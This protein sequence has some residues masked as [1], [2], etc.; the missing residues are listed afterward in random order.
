MNLEIVRN[1]GQIIPRLEWGYFLR[2]FYGHIFFPQL[3]RGGSVTVLIHPSI[4]QI[5][6]FER[7]SSVVSKICL[8]M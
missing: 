7:P 2:T 6:R 3:F 8:C 4:L 1:E 5:L